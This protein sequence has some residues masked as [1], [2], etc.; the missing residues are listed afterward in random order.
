MGWL[1]ERVALVTGAGQGIGEAIAREFVAEGAW[2]GVIDINR[3]PAESVAASLGAEARALVFDVTDREAYRRAVDAVLAER[4]K[5]DILVS[6]AAV[7]I[8][9]DIFE[10]SA[11]TWERTLAVNLEAVHWGAKLVAP[12]MSHEHW[13]RIV[14][15]TSVHAMATD[16]RVGAYCASKGGIVALTHSLAV[17]LAP[18]GILVNAVAP[19][20]I[21]TPFSVVDGVDETTTDDFRTWYVNRR[22]IPLARAGQPREVARAVVFLSSEDCSY[23]TGSTLVVDGGLT[24]TF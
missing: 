18:H 20:F 9:G 21:Q 6:N 23:V 24:V 15:I 5:I 11:S 22:K 8:P 4:G 7:S 12:S 10:D 1:E 17:E 19:G 3:Q 2:V 16:G 14:N 13:G